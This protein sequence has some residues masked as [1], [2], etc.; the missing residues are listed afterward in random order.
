VKSKPNYPTDG[1]SITEEGRS[2]SGSQNEHIGDDNCDD[3]DDFWKLLKTKDR[4]PIKYNRKL[5]DLIHTSGRRKYF[6]ISKNV[7]FGITG[8]PENRLTL[9]CIHF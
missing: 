8:V 4:I 6:R 5:A 1:C 2:N 7:T 9:N 3:I